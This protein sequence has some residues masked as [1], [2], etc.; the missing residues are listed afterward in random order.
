MRVDATIHNNTPQASAIK[1]VGNS[2]YGKFIQ[3]PQ[4][5]TKTTV[6]GPVIYKQKARRPTFQGQVE[7]S[8]TLF[9]IKELISNIKEKYPLPA[10]NT[11]LHLSKLLL[12]N[13]MV[14][15]E[16]FLVDDS[17]RILYSDTGCGLI[18]FIFKSNSFFFNFDIFSDFF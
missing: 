1:L 13:F 17:W 9:E 7:I 11:I 2:T 12:A 8:D 3:N 16:K 5:F 10:G 4:K 18:L 6:C 15:L 14:F